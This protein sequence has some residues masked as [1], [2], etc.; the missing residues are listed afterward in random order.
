MMIGRCMQC[1]NDVAIGNT[2][3]YIC[4]NCGFEARWEDSPSLQ[5]VSKKTIV[6][7]K[8]RNEA[9]SEKCNVN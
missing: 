8:F 6:P 2:C 3:G 1:G 5:S 4:N 9:L 7:R